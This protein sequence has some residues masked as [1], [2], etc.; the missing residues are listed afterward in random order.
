M[1]DILQPIK[2]YDGKFKQK[3]ADTTREYFKD[4]V[5]KSG[6]DAAANKATVAEYDAVTSD[7]MEA[8]KEVK[9][10]KIIRVVC[11]VFAVITLICGI[12]FSYF[13][14]KI[15]NGY[16]TKLSLTA[17]IILAVVFFLI[18]IGLVVFIFAYLNK[19]LDRD[20]TRAKKLNTQANELK[21]V[22]LG[23]MSSLNNLFNDSISRE[24]I[25]SV[26]PNIQI[27]QNFSIEREQMFARQYGLSDID[28]DYISTTRL[29]SGVVDGYPFLLERQKVHQMIN[30]AY[31]GVRVVTW[32]ERR[33]N[34]EGKM[35]TVR[36][37]QTLTA[38]VLRPYPD[39]NDLTFLVYGNDLL[40][41]LN[42]SRNP[43]VS[44]KSE[45]QIDK[46]VDRGEKKLEKLQDKA[47]KS[48]KSSFT[49]LANTEFEVLFGAYDR[50]NEV[51]FRMMYT[52]LAQSNTIELI[53]NEKGF[54][55]DF[56]FIKKSSLHYILAEHLQK[57]D[58]D[59]SPSRFHSHSLELSEA[60]FND[61][62]NTLFKNL[63]YNIAP[64][65]SIPLYQQH[66][67]KVHDIDNDYNKCVTAREAEVLINKLPS[68][69][70]SPAGSV[71]SNIIRTTLINSVDGVD[72]LKVTACAH[73][74]VSRVDYIPARCRN[75]RVYQVPVHWNEYI[76]IHKETVVKVGKIEAMKALED[77]R[78]A[79][80]D[81]ITERGMF[82]C[83]NK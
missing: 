61:F 78:N 50:D 82:A 25:N 2:E 9:T 81:V 63:Y 76:P 36:K 58:Y 48:G 39:Y 67:P 83:I 75:G 44:G 71:T 31:T 11:I 69:M 15:A 33:R 37:S 42:F 4:L 40:S 32:T 3:L 74:S 53:K 73:S 35:T 49:A 80:S 17:S 28:N 38:T 62:H 30:K 13:S 65:L 79:N 21:S 55:D 34:S 22:A 29:L 43:V 72:T 26:T 47:I 5:E 70:L 19:E 51:K 20:S 59:L 7:L 45:S 18:A 1:E 54:G 14:Y 6:V 46:I 57:Y 66:D 56:K 77:D 64:V 27:D 68:N 52:P 24:L 8:H 23:Q 16:E 12:V 10:G 41:S 60:T